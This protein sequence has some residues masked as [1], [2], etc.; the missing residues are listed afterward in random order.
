MAA[1]TE[2]AKITATTSRIAKKRTA[3]ITGNSIQRGSGRL[4]ERI[5]PLKALLPGRGAVE[6]RIPP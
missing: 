4:S 5:E 3:T 2:L 6:I 1:A